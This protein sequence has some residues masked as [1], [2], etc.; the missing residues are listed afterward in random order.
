MLHLDQVSLRQTGINT[1]LQTILH[2][3][4]VISPYVYQV[5]NVI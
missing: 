5:Y 3:L 2:L 1:I 4:R